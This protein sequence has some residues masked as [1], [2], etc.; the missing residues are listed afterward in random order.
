MKLSWKVV[1]KATFLATLCSP[2]AIAALIPIFYIWPWVP[3]LGA[4]LI[5]VVMLLGTGASGFGFGTLLASQKKILHGLFTSLFASVMVWL[6]IF[7][8]LYTLFPTPPSDWRLIRRLEQNEAIFNELRDAVRGEGGLEA[9]FL[10]R[11]QPSDLQTIGFSSAELKA[12]RADTTRLGLVSVR[13]HSGTPENVMFSVKQDGFSISKEYVYLQELPLHAR[14][15][16]RIRNRDVEAFGEVYRDL[17][18]GWYLLA[19][20]RSS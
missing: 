6:L 16:K 3:F 20:K 1:V 17:G 8:L 11:V 9:I 12:Y 18:N 13:E 19:Y 2:I 15:V 5:Y 4:P 7:T 14:V 10:A